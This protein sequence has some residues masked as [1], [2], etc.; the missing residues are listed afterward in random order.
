MR[1][2]RPILVALIAV[3]LAVYASDCSAMASPEQA[4]QCCQSMGMECASHGLS[5][6]DCCSSMQSAQ[7]PFVMSAA[8]SHDSFATLL[9][10]AVL[11]AENLS[12]ELNSSG[13][14]LTAQSHAPPIFNLSAPLPLRI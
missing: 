1:K 4:M 9:V 3:V 7:A 14:L 8:P 11:P 5:A 12:A 13:E 2:A 10:F 6:M